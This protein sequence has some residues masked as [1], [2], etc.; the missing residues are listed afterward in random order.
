[1]L[2]DLELVAPC[3]CNGS[4]EA[5]TVLSGNVLDPRVNGH[6]AGGG[7]EGNCSPSTVSGK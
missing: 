5:V 7:E 2:K 6:S 3:A 4:L 1:M